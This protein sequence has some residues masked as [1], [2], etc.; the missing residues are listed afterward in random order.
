MW[1]DSDGRVGFAF[2]EFL[3]NTTTAFNP[4]LGFG[5]CV[6]GGDHVTSLGNKLG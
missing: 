6:E 4:G 1:K 3:L 2:F 5:S